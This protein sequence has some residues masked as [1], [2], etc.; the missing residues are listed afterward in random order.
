MV[1]GPE[2]IKEMLIK[3]KISRAVRSADLGRLVDFALQGKHGEAAFNS[4]TARKWNK[5][6]TGVK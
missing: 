1:G 4:Y 5:M 6:P 3:Y 2:Y